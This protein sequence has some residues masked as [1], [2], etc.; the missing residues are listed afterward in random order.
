MVRVLG[1][2]YMKKKPTDINQQGNSHYSTE[3]TYRHG[4]LLAIADGIVQQRS[5]ENKGKD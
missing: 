3:Y 5:E 2:S 4:T 1:I